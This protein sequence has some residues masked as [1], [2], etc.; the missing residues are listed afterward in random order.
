MRINPELVE[1]LSEMLDLARAGKIDGGVGVFYW[2]PEHSEITGVPMCV[3]CA[4]MK[5][6]VVDGDGSVG[7]FVAAEMVR[8]SVGLALE[9]RPESFVV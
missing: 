8:R 9:R 2:N 1:R 5:S 7:T 6:Q 3:P 4:R